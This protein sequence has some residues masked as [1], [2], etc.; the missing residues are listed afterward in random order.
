[1]QTMIRDN[2]F[3]PATLLLFAFVWFLAAATPNPLE[4]G[5]ELALIFDAVVT[6]PALYFICYRKSLTRRRMAIRIVALQCLGIWLASK[7]IPT[8]EQH[9]L[10]ALKWV[11]YAGLAVL[12]LVELKLAMILFRLLFKPGVT[13]AELAQSGMPKFIAK[14]AMIEARFWR[15]LVGRFRK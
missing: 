3:W 6:L 15:W 13:E 2:W 8:S 4:P 7:L 11:R 1:M 10:P 5:F 14:W 12:V 9:I